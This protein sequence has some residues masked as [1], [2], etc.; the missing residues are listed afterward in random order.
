M[1]YET[2]KHS[3]SN[4]NNSTSSNCSSSSSSIDSKE[5]WIVAWGHSFVA[6]ASSG[7]LAATL[8]TPFDV[9]KTRRQVE[10]TSIEATSANLNLSHTNNNNNNN[11]PGIKSYNVFRALLD[12]WREEGWRGLTR[13]LTARVLKVSP[14]CAVMISSYELGKYYFKKAGKGGG[15]NSET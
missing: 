6:G 2:I 11:T 4:S 1:G 3:I 13:G 8:T 14:A 12:I 7:I 9:A 15:I 5:S 10:A